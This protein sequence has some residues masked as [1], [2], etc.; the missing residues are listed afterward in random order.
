MKVWISRDKRGY[1]VDNVSIFTVEPKTYHY[2]F[3]AEESG[4][5]GMMNRHDFKNV[6]GFTP[7]KGTC[8]QYKLSLKEIS[9]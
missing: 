7:R 4:T 5:E 8:K 9:K 2:G 3:C 1:E 6:F